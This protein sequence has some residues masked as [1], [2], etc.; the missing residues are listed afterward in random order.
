[1]DCFIKKIFEGS[2]EG[3]GLVHNQ[4][5]KFS[6][7]EFNDKAVL[8]AKKTSKGFSLN[9]TPEYGNELVACLAEELGAEKIPVSGALIT[10]IDLRDEYDF[11]EVKNALGVRKHFIEAEMSGNEILD[12]QTRFPKAFFALNFSTSTSEIKIKCKAPK[13]KPSGKGKAKLKIDFCKVKTTSESLIRNFVFD[14]DFS[15]VKLAEISHDFMIEDL[16]RPEGESD[17]AKIR[18]LSK[19][20]GTIRR[21]VSLDCG[22]QVVREVDF[23]A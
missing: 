20:K 15:K 16:V 11:K 17:F 4:F 18:E 22:D 9:T 13:T 7:G 1:M 8:K 19:R 2:S 6:K 10:T 12:L 14:V 5:Q 23:C 21:K 3:D